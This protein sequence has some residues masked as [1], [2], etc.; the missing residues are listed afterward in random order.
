[1]AE[2][3]QTKGKILL[4]KEDYS[5][6]LQPLE[7]S[8]RISDAHGFFDQA[9]T[10]TL[11]DLI[12]RLY[13]QEAT[14][15]TKNP[16]LQQQYFA[17]AG[18]YFKRWLKETPKPSADAALF[19]A[20]VLINQASTN[21]DKIDLPMVKEAQNQ[22][23]HALLLTNKP[24]ESMYQLLSFALQQEGDSQKSAEVLEL[25]V[26][27]YPNKVNYWQQLMG[28]YNLLASANEKNEALQKEYYIRTINTIERAQAYGFLKSP[29]DQYNLVTLYSLAGQF[30]KSTDLL[31]AG[32]KNGTIESDVKNWLL[33]A[34]A[35][36]QVNQ[37][38]QAASAL[39][40]AIKLFPKSAQLDFQLGQIY[41]S[42]DDT[43]QANAAYVAAASKLSGDPSD[44][45]GR[46]L[47]VCGLDRLRTTKI[48]GS[49]RCGYQRREVSGFQKGQATPSAE[50]GH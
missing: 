40:E 9:Q 45:A 27:Q 30:G 29:K 42:M 2:V 18:L 49:P 6:A 13:S 8:V 25:L 43:K 41:T 15:Q 44:K 4:Q 28:T 32:L 12:A 17:K 34:Y 1:M 26:K 24:K 3:E 47:D 19:Y 33:L 31:Y 5:G 46:H 10:L 36:Q 38:L 20:S 21:P 35:Y 7:D 16:A 23:E 11:V 50:E 39:K 22:V 48:R 37:E 14:A